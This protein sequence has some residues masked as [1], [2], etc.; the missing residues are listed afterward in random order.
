MIRCKRN[1]YEDFVTFPS[2]FCEIGK[3]FVYLQHQNV[4]CYIM[5]SIFIIQG[6][7]IYIYAFD[8]NPPHIHV[9]SG[10]DNFSITI[11]DRIIEGKARSKTVKIIND[12]IDEHKDELMK[13]WE[14]AQNGEKI[15]KIR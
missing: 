14:R 2:V 13:L 6:I 15:N 1:D 3:H 10:T 8:H 7:L 11:A 5:G 4:K 12:F 9:R